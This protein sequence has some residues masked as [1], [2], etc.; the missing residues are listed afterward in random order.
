MKSFR[1]AIKQCGLKGLYFHFA[2]PNVIIDLSNVHQ[3]LL[4]H[5]EEK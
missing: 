1:K 4:T 3:W 5:L 2:I